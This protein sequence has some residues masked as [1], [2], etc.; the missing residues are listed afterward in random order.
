M[1]LNPSLK[2]TM[3]T[4]VFLLGG[5]IAG[6]QAALE[7]SRMGLRSV[8]AEKAPFLGG[9]VAS[10]SCKATDRCQRCGACTLE[11]VLQ[12]VSLS[13]AVT[14]HVRAVAR[15]IERTGD[16]FKISLSRRPPKIFPE[17][18]SDCGK[19]E[20]V[21]PV[22]GALLRSPVDNS[23]YIAED[24]CLFFRDR[25]CRACSEVCPDA[26]VSLE[27]QAEE[28]EITSSAI[29]V[30]AGYLPFDA[31]EKPCFGYGIVPGVITSLELDSLLRKDT[32]RLERHGEEQPHVAFIQCVGSRDVK[33]GRSYCSR[34]CCANALRVARLLKTRAPGIRITFF[35][36]DLQNVD[37]DFE[38]RL[39]EA[40]QEVALVRS[41]PAEIRTGP[42]GRPQ[43][44]YHGPDDK[45]VSETADLVVLSIGMSPPALDGLLGLPTQSDGFLGNDGEKVVTN[46]DGVFVAGTVQGP[47]SIEETVSHA[48]RA[49]GEAATYVWRGPAGGPQ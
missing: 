23:L 6:L 47:K 45:R 24:R 17:V 2:Q 28:L 22:P 44:V 10:L 4:D 3:L 9:H 7:L 18:C 19:C 31:T 20:R 37:R 5:G 15:R 39:K 46:I 16:R 40:E 41:I 11:D 38:K 12:H 25:S 42:D 32:W 30:A 33:I 8:V 1:P 21:C 29:I 26:A 13:A 48:I 14:T 34:V 35:Y 43:I 36:M 49:A 27:G